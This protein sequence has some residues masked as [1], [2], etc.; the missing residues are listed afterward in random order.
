[1]HRRLADEIEHVDEKAAL[2]AEHLEAANDL[3]AAYTWHMRAAT[4]AADRDIVAAHT[5]W[6]S[7]REVADSLP[8][9]V[10]ERMAM[11]IAPRTLL[12]ASAFRVGGSGAETG[13]D[14]LRTLCDEA[15]DKRSL[16]IAMTGL[17]AQQ[18]TSHQPGSVRPRD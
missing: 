7:A 16:A 11:R 17:I 15:G 13:F 12:C 1:L 9:D 10:P 8:E 5:S 6:R 18:F 2:I 4:W 3:P 14:E